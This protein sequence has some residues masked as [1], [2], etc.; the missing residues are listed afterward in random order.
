MVI[1]LVEYIELGYNG[2]GKNA[3]FFSFF[4]IE[5]IRKARPNPSILL[6]GYKMLLLHSWV[7]V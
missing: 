7:E 3:W 5:G 1:A 6:S 4:P 2:P